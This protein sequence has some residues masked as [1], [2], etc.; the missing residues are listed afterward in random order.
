MA[1]QRDLTITA[2]H[3]GFPG[4][5]LGA[6]AGGLLAAEL[7]PAVRVRFRRPIPIDVP[8]ALARGT[9]EATLALGG[10]VVAEAHLG[11][12]DVGGAPIVS[13]DAAGE[14]GDRYIGHERHPYP[15]CFCCG[16]A[17]GSSDGLR[18]FVGPV[19][20]GRAVAGLWTAPR[21]L[22]DPSGRLPMEI[23]WSVIDC[24]GIWALIVDAPEDS[25]E[26]VV[27]G[28]LDVRVDRPLR[29]ETRYVVTA[30]PMGR[31]GRRMYAGTVVSDERGEV[32][33]TAMQTCVVSSPGVPLG[34]STWRST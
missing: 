17:R 30:W 26:Q 32:V 22:A 28:T 12:V 25:D 6:Y 16:P 1:L 19:R 4:L 8:L 18:V 3:S 21:A 11:D 15:S 34:L 29:P 31:E 9:H 23:A 27:T 14:A 33:V 10:V 7:G 2:R 13:V 20:G 24:P 5:A